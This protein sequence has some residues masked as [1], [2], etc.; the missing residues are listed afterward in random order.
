MLERAKKGLANGGLTPYGYIRQDKKLIPHSKEAE[1]IKSI[2]ETYVESGSTAKTY[3]M[4]KDKGVKNDFLFYQQIYRWKI[5]PI[6][7]LSLHRHD[8]ARLASV[9]GKTSVRRTIRRFLFGK[10]RAHFS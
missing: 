7:L 4:L 10:F 6:L 9:L 3:Q 8:E 2:F 5:K 1:E